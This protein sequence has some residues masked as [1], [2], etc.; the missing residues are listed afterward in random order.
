MDLIKELGYLMEVGKPK[1]F[2]EFIPKD[3]KMDQ[4]YRAIQQ[5]KV[6]N[7][8]EAARTIYDSSSKDK[9]YLM[10]KSN[11][12]KKLSEL[13]L[14]SEHTESKKKNFVKNKFHLLQQLTLAEKMLFQSVYFNAE[15]ITLKVLAEAEKISLSEV[16]IKCYQLLRRINSLKGNM[17]EAKRYHQKLVSLVQNWV[18]ENESQ[19]RVEILLSQTKYSRAHASVVVKEADAYIEELNTWRS[20]YSDPFIHLNYYRTHLIRLFQMNDWQGFR[21]EMAQLEALLKMNPFL[22]T[23]I[24]RQEINLHQIR[25][26]I[27]RRNLSDAGLLTR[28]TLKLTDYRAYNKFQFQAEHVDIL[29]KCKAY[30]K[31]LKI[32][33]E[34]WNTPEFEKLDKAELGIW[35]IK[36]AFLMVIYELTGTKN[37]LKKDFNLQD[38]Y[39]RCA[40]I[41]KDKLGYNLQFLCVRLLLVWLLDKGDVDNE[42]HNLKIYYQRYLK[43]SALERTRFFFQRLSRISRNYFNPERCRSNV[44]DFYE[45]LRPMNDTYDYCELVPYDHLMDMIAKKAGIQN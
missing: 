3:S 14:L 5:G 34:V 24:L 13:V 44:Y 2:H 12:I 43:D 15:K 28:S 39:V 31:S 23:I 7:D 33:N 6:S 20:I 38:F 4:L 16:K 10:L 8:E 26:N 45:Q 37:Q 22:E 18:I 35:E 17:V 36:K 11:L 21:E 1:S 19:G 9:K 42:G 29:I 25:Y 40:P 32:L 41:N 30:S 27:C